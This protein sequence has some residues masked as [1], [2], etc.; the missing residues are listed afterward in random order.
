MALDAKPDIV[1]SIY[2]Q[3]S[4]GSN[5]QADPIQQ[6]QFI[7][8]IIAAEKPMWVIDIVEPVGFPNISAMNRHFTGYA[9]RDGL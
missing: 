1:H 4:V 8:R 5:K 3:L 9:S 2:Q 6:L 7:V